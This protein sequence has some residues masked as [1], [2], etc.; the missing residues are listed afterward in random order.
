MAWWHHSISNKRTK[1]L[2]A[3]W[4]PPFPISPLPPPPPP[5]PPPR[6][7]PPPPPR[8][9]PPPHAP[10][11]HPHHP[12]HAPPPPPPR[13]ST[14]SRALDGRVALFHVTAHHT[15]VTV[16]VCARVRPPYCAVLQTD[17]SHIIARFACYR[18]PSIMRN[19]KRTILYNDWLVTTQR[20]MMRSKHGYSRNITI[21]KLIKLRV[22]S[23][24]IIGGVGVPRIF[25][26]APCTASSV[27]YSADSSGA[28]G[29]R[30]PAG[31]TVVV[32][33]PAAHTA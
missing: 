22:Q 31:S 27:F 8:H 32:D 3:W 2:I 5:P 12:P 20:Q 33:T 25:R 21:L 13:P 15:V 14:H 10:H 11:L 29:R 17:T 1:H 7:P 16:T 4:D 9:P 6:P 18:P 28:C 23:L 30:Y 26:S 19:C 24:V